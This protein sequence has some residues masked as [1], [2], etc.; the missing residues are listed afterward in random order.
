[1]DAPVLS[2]EFWESLRVSVFRLVLCTY[3]PTRIS[4]RKAN[5]SLEIYADLNSN[6]RQILRSLSRDPDRQDRRRRV[7]ILRE[8][9]P[10]HTEDW[11]KGHGWRG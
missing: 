1:V 3:C 4:G 10:D 7:T 5:V 9:P 6:R 11:Q 8:G 2:T